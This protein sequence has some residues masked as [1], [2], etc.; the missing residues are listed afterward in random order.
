[1]PSGYFDAKACVNLINTQISR[2]FNIDSVVENYSNSQLIISKQ[3]LH[4]KGVQLK[5]VQ[6]EVN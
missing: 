4:Q 5:K 2:K 3:R 1:M 6:D